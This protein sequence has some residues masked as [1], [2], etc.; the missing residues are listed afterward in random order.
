[1]LI[2]HEALEFPSKTDIF[3]RVFTVFGK[4]DVLRVLL[5]N[6]QSIV[7]EAAT[8]RLKHRLPTP[9]IDTL[10]I[11]VINGVTSDEALL[12]K[13]FGETKLLKEFERAWI[14]GCRAAKCCLDGA[15]T[16]LCF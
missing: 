16:F 7:V 4:D 1:M 6:V 3:S 11:G 15:L 13:V 14:E 12:T 2:Y 8:E 10:T 9:V 5:A